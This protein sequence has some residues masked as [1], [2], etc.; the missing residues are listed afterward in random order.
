GGTLPAALALSG[1]ALASTSVGAGTGVTPTTGSSTST[2]NAS[3]G[4]T[5]GRADQPLDPVWMLMLGAAAWVLR[6]RRFF[7]V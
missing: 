6:R 4:C 2:A 3:G 7:P 1:T 5:L